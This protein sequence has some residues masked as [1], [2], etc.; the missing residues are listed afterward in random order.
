MADWLEDMTHRTNKPL[1]FG[2]VSVDNPGEPE[3]RWRN[4]AFLVDPAT[5]VQYPGYA[6]RKLV[7]FGEYIPLRPRAR[8]AGEI[9]AHRRRLR[10]RRIRRCRSICPRARITPCQSAC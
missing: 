1:L 10:P 9:R 5:G 7:P 8:L 4:G 3:E 6:K 2:A